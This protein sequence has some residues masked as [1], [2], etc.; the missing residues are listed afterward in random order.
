MKKRKQAKA[1]ARKRAKASNKVKLVR[2]AIPVSSIA[3]PEGFER[4][5]EPNKKNQARYMKA[6]MNGTV[7]EL[8]ASLPQSEMLDAEPALM[9]MKD[10]LK[11]NDNSYRKHHFN[12]TLI[13]SKFLK[14]V[15]RANKCSL[16]T[17][18]NINVI[19]K[20]VVTHSF[21]QMMVCE[22]HI[23]AFVQYSEN[24]KA[25]VDM[26]FEDYEIFSVSLDMAA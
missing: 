7:A 22:K 1:N 9:T 5:T 14:E 13:E 18:L 20:P 10:F 2:K 11:V 17:V 3:D 23:R 16:E 19:V 8:E 4:V 26:T 12:R 21:R 6:V 15:A 24:D 25:I